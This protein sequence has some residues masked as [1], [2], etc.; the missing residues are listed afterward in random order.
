MAVPVQRGGHQPHPL[1]ELEKGASYSE[2]EIIAKL[3]IVLEV[4]PA[5]FLRTEPSTPRRD[6]SSG[7][8]LR[9]V[10]RRNE[11]RAQPTNDAHGKAAQPSSSISA[12]AS[13]RSAVSKPS[14]NQP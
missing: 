6:L 7:R 5:E 9:P 11:I 13:F 8:P 2:L 3:A 14:V 12:F 10:L 4:E 1:S